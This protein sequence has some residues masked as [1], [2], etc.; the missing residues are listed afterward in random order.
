MLAICKG[1]AA[2]TRFHRVR[3]GGD[4]GAYRGLTSPSALGQLGPTEEAAGRGSLLL[5][6]DASLG[7][8]SGRDR[9]ES[10]R[11]AD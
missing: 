9:R 11:P 1:D 7:E 4:E 10:A 8:V 2:E 5:N 6:V 3:R